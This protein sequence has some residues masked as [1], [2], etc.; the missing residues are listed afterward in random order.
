MSNLKGDLESISLM[1]VVQ[2]LHVNRKSGMLQVASGKDGGVLYF[3]RGEIVHAESQAQRGEMAAFEILEWATGQFEFLS[4]QIQA[5]STIRRTV[6]DLLMDSARQSD[7]RKR[8]HVLFPRLSAVPW[9]TLP[10]MELTAGLKVFAED[11]QVIPFFDGYRD[12]EDVMKASGQNDVAVMQAAAI[13][14]DAGRLVVLEPDAHLTLVTMKTGLFKKGDHLELPKAMEGWWR[15]LGP[16][17]HGVHNVRVMWA[18]GPA[19]EKVEFVSGLL[20]HLLA[21]PRELMVAWDLAEGSHV[22]VRPAP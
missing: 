20:D 22:K 16:Y 6:P 9:P 13:L 5:P 11:R 14:K 21:I 10:L 15:S 12:F 18:Q 7:S 8:L 4:T 1:D 17:A 19:V 2:L 3:S